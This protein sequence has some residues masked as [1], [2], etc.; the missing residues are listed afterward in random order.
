MRFIPSLV[1]A[2]LAAV[3]LAAFGLH[4]VKAASVSPATNW[5]IH[6]DALKHFPGH[7]D[8][9]AHHWCRSI[10]NGVLECQI[11]SSDN[12]NAPLVAIETIVPTAVWKKFPPSEQ[13][14]WH[15]HRIEI[16]KVSATMPDVSAAEAKKVVASLLETYGK[17]YILWNPAV[18]KYSVGQPTVYNM[19]HP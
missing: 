19:E 10:G 14:L 4:S 5:T 8:E 1:F 12:A 11:Y 17:I 9:V 7:P 6:I 15:Y 16:P 13:M 2:L 18:S 3:G